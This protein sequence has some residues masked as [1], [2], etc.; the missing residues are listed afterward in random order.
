MVETLDL[1]TSYEVWTALQVAYR[2][3]S[4]EQMHVLKDNLRQLQKGTFIVSKFGAKLKS[5]CDQL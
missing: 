2:Q 4:H 1:T 5:L 3:D